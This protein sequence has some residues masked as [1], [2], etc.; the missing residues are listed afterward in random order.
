[1]GLHYQNNEWQWT[2]GTAFDYNRWN[3]CSHDTCAYL[4]SDIQATDWFGKWDNCHECSDTRDFA[5]CKRS[6]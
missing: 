1:M 2:D 5:V 6:P 4:H 3:G